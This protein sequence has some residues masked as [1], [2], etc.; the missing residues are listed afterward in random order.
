MNKYLERIHCL[1][2]KKNAR[3]VIPETNDN[4]VQEAAT[5]L[6]DLSFQIIDNQ[7]MYGQIDI[8]LDYINSLPFTKNWQKKNKL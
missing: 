7:D 4:R 6:K 1:G 2:K 5:K 8:Y 3:V